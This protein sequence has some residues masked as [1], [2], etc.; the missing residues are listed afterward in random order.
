MDF[1]QVA[2]ELLRAL[3]G[4]RSQVMFSRRLG[5]R[6]NVAYSWESGRRWPTAAVALGAANRAKVDVP[7]AVRGFFRSA[8][9]WLER[10][11]PA[12]SEGVAALLRDLRGQTPILD[13]A[14]RSGRSRYAVA[15][16]LSGEA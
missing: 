5:Y 4:K 14:R 3:R 6:T 8:P 11:D 16:W 10:L 1:D 9:P 15:R 12:S 13:L 7:A 2:R